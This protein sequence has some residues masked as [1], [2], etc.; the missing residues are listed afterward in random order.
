MVAVDF[1]E[2]SATA[3]AAA[4]AL[5]RNLDASLL[6][7]NVVNQRDVDHAKK[8]A[9]EFPAYSVDRYLSDA[10]KSREDQ[11]R[12]LIDA[13]GC[14]ALKPERKIRV[15]TPFVELLAEIEETRPDLLVIATKGRSNLA[16]VVLGSCAQKMFRR[17]PIPLLS[18]RP[19][20]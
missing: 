3:L 10:R 19:P 13:V 15:G 11:F 5:C 4:A 7:V 8:V 2:H 17:C 12:R 18:V 20:R 6:L 9:A 14:A 1:S 16:D